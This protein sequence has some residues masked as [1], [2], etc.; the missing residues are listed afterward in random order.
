MHQLRGFGVA[1]FVLAVGFTARSAHALTFTVNTLSDSHDKTL[2][3]QKCVDSSIKCSLR[4]AIEEANRLNAAVTLVVKA[5]T[6]NL[7]TVAGFG[8]LDV[9]AP[10]LAQRRTARKVELHSALL[11]RKAVPGG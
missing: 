3:D 8:E 2:G 7:N 4:A 11:G 10:C 1:L 9:L 5:G 6:F